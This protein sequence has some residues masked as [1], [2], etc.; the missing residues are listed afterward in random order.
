MGNINFNIWRIKPSLCR[1]NFFSFVGCF[2]GFVFIKLN[3]NILAVMGNIN[4]NIRRIKP[5]LCCV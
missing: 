3:L 1:I 5:S 4:L 2:L